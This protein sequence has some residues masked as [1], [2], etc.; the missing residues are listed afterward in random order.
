[1]T[2]KTCA[3]CKSTFEISYFKQNKKTGKYSSYC[4]DCQKIKVRESYLRHREEIIQ[5]AA[6]YAA[7]NKDSVSQYQAQYRAEHR[8]E[9]NQAERVRYK[10]KQPEIREKIKHKYATDPEYRAKVAISNSAKY[11]K[12]K[13]RLE[14]DPAYAEAFRKKTRKAARKHYQKHRV[15]ILEQCRLEYA[16]DVEKGRAKSR[17]SCGM[18]RSRHPEEVRA[19]NAARK[20]SM[21]NGRKAGFV[22]G[23]HF[24][25]LAEWQM[26]L[27]Y[28]CNQPMTWDNPKN[29]T[30]GEREHIVPCTRLKG[31]HSAQ[32]LVWSCKNCN[33]PLKDER[34]LGLEWKPPINSIENVEIHED[35]VLGE[36]G[37]KAC[38]VISTFLASSRNLPEPRTWMQ[39]LDQNLPIFFDFEWKERRE[40]IRNIV[41]Y[42]LGNPLKSTHAR[43]CRIVEVEL[44]DA[45]DFL[46][47]WHIQ[48]WSNASIYLGLVDVFGDL[49]QITAWIFNRNAVEL[50]RMASW[51][52]VKGG[53]SK[54]LKYFKENFLPEGMPIISFCDPRYAKNLGKSYAAMG[55]EYVGDTEHQIYYYVGPAGLGHRRG[56]QKKLMGSKLDY[57]DPKL[58][59]EANAMANGLYRLY[60]FKQKRYLLRS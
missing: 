2:Q 12:H 44:D 59:E 11:L 32:N 31:S 16:A 19:R 34:I 18:W 60:G 6:E 37:H 25:H 36:F 55:F 33:Y 1:M 43:S 3:L 15:S 7:N 24:D 26:G 38:Y 39:G 35:Q 22:E 40:A 49:V 14:A 41:Q 4:R 51:G 29:P 8:Q 47:Q 17:K 20:A 23:A 9:L 56:Y 28:Y 48:G 53:F 10:A 57:F 30:F 52:S 50:A 21:R 27:C 54:L 58:S 13:D 42:R 46:N 45:R 5:K